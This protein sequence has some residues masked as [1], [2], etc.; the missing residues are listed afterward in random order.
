MKKLSLKIKS[1]VCIIV[2]L[3]ILG[4]SNI[5]A[6][7]QFDIGVGMV[8]TNFTESVKGLGAIMPISFG[9]TTAPFV[10]KTYFSYT[11]GRY[12]TD[13]NKDINPFDFDILVDL[14]LGFPFTQGGLL[15]NLHLLTPSIFAI[16]IG[17]GGGYA[18]G[19]DLLGSY[20][21]ELSHGP[22]IRGS[23]PISLGTWGMSLVAIFDYYFMEKNY[24]QFG[25]FMKASF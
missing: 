5:H 8:K 17:I 13:R 25:G 16:G 3:F 10:T 9:Y 22:Y 12:V 1:V 7:F 2:F 11:E 21:A 6:E 23:I 24:M 19:Y 14:C 18:L 15:F 4:V 20:D